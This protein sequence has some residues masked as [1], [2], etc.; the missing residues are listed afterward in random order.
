M[1][2]YKNSLSLTESLLP[3]RQEGV[4]IRCAVNK[5][6]R[7]TLSKET[8][9]LQDWEGAYRA[10]VL[11]TDEHKLMGKIDSAMAVLR[12]CLLELDSSPEHF[13]ERQRI[14]DALRTLEMIRRIELNVPA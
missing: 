6:A 10:A 1:R 12:A 7:K 2:F 5:T 4:S 14:S 13:D 11:E 9:M 8:D 3:S